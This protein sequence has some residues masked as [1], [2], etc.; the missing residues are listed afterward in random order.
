[1]A[2]TLS[3]SRFSAEGTTFDCVGASPM[4]ASGNYPTPGMLHWQSQ[5]CW[6]PSGIITT[7]T[8]ASTGTTN[9]SGAGY[10]YSTSPVEFEFPT[11]TMDHSPSDAWNPS[12]S[13]PTL[14]AD[15]SPTPIPEPTYGVDLQ[16]TGI[17]I[18]SMFFHHDTANVKS[19]A[20]D[21]CAILADTD[22]EVQSPDELSKDQAYVDHADWTRSGVPPSPIHLDKR[23]IGEQTLDM[24]PWEIPSEHQIPFTP[25]GLHPQNSPPFNPVYSAPR[26]MYTMPPASAPPLHSP[27]ATSPPIQ[28]LPILVPTARNPVFAPSSSPSDIGSIPS[29]PT[30][31]PVCTNCGT[32]H[33]SLWRRDKTSGRKLC[34]ACKLFSDL[35]GVMRPES[36]WKT[37]FVKRRR[38]NGSGDSDTL[39]RKRGAGAGKRKVMVPSLVRDVRL[40]DFGMT[41]GVS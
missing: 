24:D 4:S 39:A 37:G 23:G 3:V 33:T 8:A 19:A 7:T 35:H 27:S 9:T 17:F 36:L 5:G 40:A 22:A 6:G 21:M 28:S 10:P 38:R 15:L 30:S 1:M 34:N 26:Y 29:A 13:I 25:N 31:P 18:D 16:D 41:P 2:L 14:A 32:S 11:Q 12:F 20:V